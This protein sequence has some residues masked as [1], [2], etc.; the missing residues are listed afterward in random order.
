MGQG[1]QVESVDG[2]VPAPGTARSGGI[3]G[4]H[5]EVIFRVNGRSVIDLRVS[6]ERLDD[7]P[8][9]NAQDPRM[10]RDGTDPLTAGSTWLTASS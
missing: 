2:G 3:L 8:G 9:P 5:D 7:E 6:L 10:I 1:P 4:L